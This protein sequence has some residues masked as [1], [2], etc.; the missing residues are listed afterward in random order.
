M[1]KWYASKTIWANVIALAAT[2]AGVFGFDLGLTADAQAQIVAGI[3]AV[4]N[5][6]LRLVTTQ[7]IGSEK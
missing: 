5:I 6:V 7:P 3:M 4:V 1:K 2:M